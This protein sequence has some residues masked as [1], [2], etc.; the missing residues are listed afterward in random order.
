MFPIFPSNS[1]AKASELLGNLEEMM[2]IV[3][4]FTL[5]WTVQENEL[6]GS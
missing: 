4:A 3:I 2:S 1:K 6:C 5:W